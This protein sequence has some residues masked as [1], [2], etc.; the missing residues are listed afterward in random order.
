MPPVAINA[1][2]VAMLLRSTTREGSADKTRWCIGA[3]LILLFILHTLTVLGQLYAPDSVIGNLGRTFD[4]DVEYNV[5]TYINSL[6]L[7]TGASYCVALAIRA[8]WI[9]HRVGWYIFATA[10][11]YFALDESLLIH[12][13]VAEPL[14]K[15]WHIQ[16]NSPF[17]HA[18]VIPGMII[19]VVLGLLVS[20]LRNQYRRLAVFNNIVLYIF[21][22]AAGAILLEIL[23]TFA[24]RNGTFYRLVMVLLEEGFEL[25]M[26]VAI[27]LMLR[28]TY[29]SNSRAR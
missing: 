17:F 23:G 1:M 8:K 20:I 13:Q 28:H 16:A 6:F 25:T 22:L 24:F 18:W 3:I 12:E 27:L 2:L 26:S 5:P 15:L 4:L 11:A 7:A 21:I 29:N 14:R 10:L 9:F 19:L